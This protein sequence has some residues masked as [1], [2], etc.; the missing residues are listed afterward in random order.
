MR[1]RSVHTAL[2]ARLRA[3]SARASGWGVQRYHGF[4]LLGTFPPFSL[5]PRSAYGAMGIVCNSVFFSRFIARGLDWNGRLIYLVPELRTALDR[6]SRDCRVTSLAKL[7]RRVGQAKERGWL[8]KEVP[9]RAVGEELDQ[10]AE[11]PSER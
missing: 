2:H 1:L 7:L 10:I 8:N 9:C 6:N 5:G 3:I 4:S 11:G